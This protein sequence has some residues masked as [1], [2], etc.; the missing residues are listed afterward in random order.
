MNKKQGSPVFHEE[1]DAIDEY[2]ECVTACSLGDEE[3]ECL[4]QCVQV[5]LKTEDES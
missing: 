3:I 2:F 1:V 4:T 5:H